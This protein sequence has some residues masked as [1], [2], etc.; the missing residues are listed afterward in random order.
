LLT[1]LLVNAFINQETRSADLKKQYKWHLFIY[2]SMYLNQ[3]IAKCPFRFLSQGEICLL[4]SFLSKHSKVEAVQS[5]TS[6]LACLISSRQ[7]G[8]EG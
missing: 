5:T 4:H 2:Q 6:K 1:N 3:D 7:R 8:R